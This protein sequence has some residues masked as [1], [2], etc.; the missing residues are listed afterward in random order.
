MISKTKVQIG[1]LDGA[2]IETPAQSGYYTFP[3]TV[4][5]ESPSGS[6]LYT[7]GPLNES[8]PGLY[9]IPLPVFS[10]L[11]YMK[12]V[13]SNIRSWSV[14]EDA[15][16]IDPSNY[17]GGIGQV[18]VDALEAENSLLALSKELYL[19]DSD[20]GTIQTVVR[21]VNTTNGLLSMVADS[22]LG[23]FN[24]Y[25]T[26]QPQITT[27]GA[28]IGYYMGVVGL[29]AALLVDPSIRTRP[30]V[31]PGWVGN[32]WDHIK[33]IMSAE[34]IEMSCVAGTVMVRPL[35]TR[36][37]DLKR[38]TT[39]SKTLNKQDVSEQIEV[40]WYNNTAINKGEV[41]PVP[42]EGDRPAAQVVEAG[43]TT[44]FEIQMDASLTSVNQ[45]VAIDYVLNQSYAGTDGVYSVTATDTLPVTA[46]QWNA[47]GG[48]VRVRITDDPSVLEVTIKGMRNSGASKGPFQIAMSSGETYNSLHI[49][50]Q[51]VSWNRQSTVLYTGATNNVTGEK[52]GVTV[53]NPFIS[54]YNQALNAGQQ[55]SK[56]Y[57]RTHTLNTSVV[58]KTG[59][60][61]GQ[62]VGSRI[63]TPDANYRV[64]SV[65]VGPTLAEVSAIE[66]STMAD[67][68]AEWAG[69]P[70]EAFA[71]FWSGK[72]M[73]EFA[74]TPLR[75]T[76]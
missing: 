54:T 21:E 3:D 5:F 30:V 39:Q 24:S 61:F 46:A 74:T 43:G 75:S 17:S 28:A 20:A 48:S 23:L 59:E 70:A 27:L 49:T 6:G 38:S 4:H 33:Q 53:E 51:G 56:T 11:G 32:V 8:D 76:E 44:V 15:T 36:V 1:T 12:G 55:T 60:L 9:D 65:S 71:N 42:S 64:E 72:T 13:T 7:V 41:Y 40:F 2:Y 19:E 62:T 57:S 26:V 66:D 68:A 25:H 14:Q 16:T 18:T 58:S 73:L 52:I 67:F 63:L 47:N 29:N 22:P 35:R 50:G 34:Q 45:P 69:K 37:A 31:Y 10:A